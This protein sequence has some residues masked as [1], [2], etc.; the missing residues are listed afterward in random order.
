MFCYLIPKS[1]KE[2]LEFDKENRNTKWADATRGEMD[3]IKKQEVFT[4]CQ[5]PN[6]IQTTNESY[7][8]LST[9]KRSG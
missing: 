3:C 6:V 8:H 9:T 5:E 7:M 2:A 4:T 1:H